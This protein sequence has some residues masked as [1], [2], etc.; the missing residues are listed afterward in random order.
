M[1]TIYVEGSAALEP[2]AADWLGHLI[3][4]GHELVLVASPDHPSAG[5]VE[6]V[7]HLPAMPDETSPG[8]WFVTADPTTCGDRRSNLRTVLVGPKPDGSRP[9]RCDTTARDLR[10]A[11][12][13]ILASDAMA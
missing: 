13:E 8:S 6:W 12:L 5:L 9:T 1:I 7:G 11:V 4:A 2:A 3:D 10:E